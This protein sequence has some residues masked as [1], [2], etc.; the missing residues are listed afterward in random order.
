MDLNNKVCVC[1]CVCA[2]VCTCMHSSFPKGEGWCLMME[3]LIRPR[4]GGERRGAGIGCLRQGG[5]F[6]FLQR[7]RL[8]TP[9]THTLCISLHQPIYAPLSPPGSVAVKVFT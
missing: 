1:V 5:N 4:D 7:A 9:G 6:F 2:Y 3:H 8:E